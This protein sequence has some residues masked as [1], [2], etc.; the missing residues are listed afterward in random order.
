[1]SDA[2]TGPSLA[3]QP[4]EDVVDARALTEASSLLPGGHGWVQDHHGLVLR[5][6]H[7]PTPAQ[8][9]RLPFQSSPLRGGEAERYMA[10]TVSEPALLYV[11]PLQGGVVP[12]GGCPGLVC[13]ALSGRGRQRQGEEGNRLF[14]VAAGAQLFQD[15]PLG[16]GI[17]HHGLEA[18]AEGRHVAQGALEH[19]QGVAQVHHALE[20]RHLLADVVR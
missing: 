13:F 8:P 19:G 11:S 3:G 4:Q 7:H 18:L 10:S 15:A 5:G 1:M 6:H 9:R 16:L 12:Q 20:L 17:V 14:V 2:N